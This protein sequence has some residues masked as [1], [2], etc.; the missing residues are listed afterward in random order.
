MPRVVEI[1]LRKTSLIL[2]SCVEVGQ[3]DERNGLEEKVK[4]AYD[5]SPGCTTATVEA[6]PRPLTWGVVII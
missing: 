3:N 2:F 1:S 4:E 6:Q 5:L